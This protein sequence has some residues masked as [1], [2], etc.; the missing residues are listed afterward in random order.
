[1]H[2]LFFVTGLILFL[3]SLYPAFV[4]SNWFSFLIMGSGIFLLAMGFFW[5]N[6][7]FAKH[8]KLRE[9]FSALF[10]TAL[11]LV[12][13]VSTV[14]FTYGYLN[15][16]MENTDYTVVVLG[17][18]IE[19]SSPSLMLRGR[20]DKA[21]EYLTANPQA[22]VVV[23]GG[24]GEGATLSEAE[25]MKSYLVAQG[26]AENR[27]FMEPNSHNTKE[28]IYNSFEVIKINNLSDN[29]VIVSDAF[30]I[31]RGRIYAE[32]LEFED[33]SPLAANTPWYMITYYTLREIPA[34]FVAVVS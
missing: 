17:C 10:L 22:N 5:N 27:I 30:H 29:I 20:L 13:S 9:A 26:I 18:K 6:K 15:S 32:K 28:N 7:K 31:L 2:L 23:A 33:I 24:V 4:S 25:V 21:A 12:A 1:M 16:P 34:I 3:N 11:T 14:I 8:K 19:G